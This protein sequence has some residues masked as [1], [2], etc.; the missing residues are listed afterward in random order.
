M[1]L[2]SL[3]SKKGSVRFLEAIV[4]KEA[5]EDQTGLLAAKNVWTG[6]LRAHTYLANYKENNDALGVLL[7]MHA[8]K[9][10]VCSESS[11]VYPHTAI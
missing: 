7:L 4:P 2:K 11:T 8:D 5:S 1:H 3:P 10:S 6:T 9:V